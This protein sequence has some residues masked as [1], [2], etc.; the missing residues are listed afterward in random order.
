MVVAVP[1]GHSV[2]WLDTEAVAQLLGNHDLPLHP[3][4]VS[5][6][7]E[8]NLTR[9]SQLDEGLPA[10]QMNVVGGDLRQGLR[11]RL[12]LKALLFDHGQYRLSLLSGCR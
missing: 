8:Y 4:P 2:A 3:N 10:D 7:K 6:T 5:H 12:R 1:K 9:L 11:R